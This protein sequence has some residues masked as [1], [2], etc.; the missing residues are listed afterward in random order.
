R[1]SPAPTGSART[2]EVVL[3]WAPGVNIA[4]IDDVSE[5]VVQ[6]KHHP[7]IV[8]GFGDETQ[9]TVVYDPQLTTPDA[10]RRF[11]T[12]MGFPTRP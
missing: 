9:I 2:S 11:L 1:T 5:I 3:R 6:L 12:D 8:G 7:G 4:D 10:I